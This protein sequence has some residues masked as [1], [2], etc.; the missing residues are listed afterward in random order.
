M[1]QTN[2]TRIKTKWLFSILPFLLHEKISESFQPKSD[3]NRCKKFR[4]ALKIAINTIEANLADVSHDDFL[5]E[6]PK[7]FNVKIKSSCFF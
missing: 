5:K 7:S 4:D 1:R 6:A 2:G 3:K